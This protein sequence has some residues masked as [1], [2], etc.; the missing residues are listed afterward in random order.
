MD[1][2]ILNFECLLNFSE[3][4]PIHT[5]PLAWDLD[6]RK[7]TKEPDEATFSTM[8]FRWPNQFLV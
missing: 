2:H 3:L 4:F 1:L 5:P 7:V 8:R 6:H